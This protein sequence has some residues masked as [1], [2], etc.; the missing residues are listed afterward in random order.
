MSARDV[1]VARVFN[2]YLEIKTRVENLGHERQYESRQNANA[3]P[4]GSLT[5]PETP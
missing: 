5:L 1:D 2:P 3:T 4:M